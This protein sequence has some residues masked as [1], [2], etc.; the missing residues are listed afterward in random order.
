MFDYISAIYYGESFGSC[1]ASPLDAP[2]NG[3]ECKLVRQLERVRAELGGGFA[4]ELS[5]TLRVVLGGRQLDAFRE[6]VRTGSQLAAS[7]LV[8][9]Q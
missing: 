3:T 9:P 5:C 6:G 8:D 2:A 7:L 4:G 1:P